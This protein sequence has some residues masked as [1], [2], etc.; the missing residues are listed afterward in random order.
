MIV[1][2]NKLLNL[3]AEQ[4]ADRWNVTRSTVDGWRAKRIGLPYLKIG[5]HVRYRLE[6]IEAYERTRLFQA[7]LRAQ[8]SVRSPPPRASVT[9][10]RQ[11]TGFEPHPDILTD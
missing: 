3:T 1:I 9:P 6:D 4:L 10:G 2:P 8:T 5:R 11:Y 7:P